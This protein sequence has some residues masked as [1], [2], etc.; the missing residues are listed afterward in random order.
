MAAI[1]TRRG[2]ARGMGTAACGLVG[3]PPPGVGLRSVAGD[4][5][6]AF[7]WRSAGQMVPVGRP[8]RPRRWRTV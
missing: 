8:P 4:Q 2:P 7:E 3:A 5:P 1:P 6:G